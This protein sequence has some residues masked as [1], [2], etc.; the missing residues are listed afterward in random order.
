M[1]WDFITTANRCGC[2]RLQVCTN[3]KADRR[4]QC[5]LITI[6]QSR[7][8]SEQSQ[9]ATPHTIRNNNVRINFCSCS[10]ICQVQLRNAV[11]LELKSRT[12]NS[13]VQQETSRLFRAQIYFTPAS[14]NEHRQWIKLIAWNSISKTRRAEHASLGCSSLSV[15]ILNSQD[16]FCSA[17]HGQHS[18]A[19]ADLLNEINSKHWLKALNANLCRKAA[20]RQL[21]IYTHCL[22]YGTETDCRLFSLIKQVN[23]LYGY[24]DRVRKCFS[25]LRW[26]CKIICRNGDTNALETERRQGFMDANNPIGNW[27]QAREI[28]FWYSK[29]KRN[30]ISVQWCISWTKVW[31]SYANF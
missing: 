4:R 30:N 17:K 19:P 20:A 22:I 7:L 13:N 6:K 3:K 1:P 14:A 10:E 23:S 12:R 15:V 24:L 9:I 18:V 16:I 28:Y 26:N 29:F 11:S 2:T 8:C 27:R 5:P 31:G 25:L 21:S